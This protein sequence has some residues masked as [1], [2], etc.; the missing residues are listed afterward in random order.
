MWDCKNRNFFHKNGAEIDLKSK[1][2]EICKYYQFILLN[3]VN[4]MTT[5]NI[6]L[7]TH[8]DKLWAII[9][10]QLNKKWQFVDC[11]PFFEHQKVL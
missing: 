9:G 6:Q 4:K 7:A 8:F 3:Q 1:K 10:I 11:W 5:Y 2:N